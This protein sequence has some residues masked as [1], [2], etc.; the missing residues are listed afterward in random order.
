LSRVLAK[1]FDH[2]LFDIGNTYPENTAEHT[3]YDSISRSPAVGQVISMHFLWDGHFDEDVPRGPFRWSNDCLTSCLE[4]ILNDVAAA[5][6]H[7]ITS[8]NEEN[9]GAEDEH[10]EA[11]KTRAVAERLVRLLP[12]IFPPPSANSPQNA[13][14][15]TTTT[16]SFIIS[17]P[18]RPGD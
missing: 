10:E 15:F 11:E 9:E 13:P 16:S 3:S 2:P 1:L 17:S 7:P 18:T 5:L 6:M 12:R 4:L 14:S 8:E